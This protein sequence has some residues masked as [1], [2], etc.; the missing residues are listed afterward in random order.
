[1]WGRTFLPRKVSPGNRTDGR[2]GDTFFG[3][4]EITILSAEFD[5]LL[6]SV[7][8]VPLSYSESIAAN[9]SK[10]LTGRDGRLTDLMT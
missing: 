8:D 4:K 6:L 9:R 7:T 1:V 2:S 10:T 5:L 3:K